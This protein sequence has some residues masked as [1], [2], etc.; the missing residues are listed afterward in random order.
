MFELIIYNNGTVVGGYQS[1]A[2]YPVPNI[3][4]IVLFTNKRYKVLKVIY[5]YRRIDVSQ[6]NRL[7]VHLYCENDN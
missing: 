1:T 4:N 3:G 2:V 5:D 6:N 7:I